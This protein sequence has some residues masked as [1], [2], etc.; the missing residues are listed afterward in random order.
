MGHESTM[1]SKQVKN[2]RTPQLLQTYFDSTHTIDP[3][4]GL[5]DLAAAAERAA[6]RKLLL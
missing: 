5:I 2:T 6:A 3:T 1:N 4:P